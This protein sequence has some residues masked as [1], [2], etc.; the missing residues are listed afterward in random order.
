MVICVVFS[1]RCD[2]DEQDDNPAQKSQAE[3]TKIS[4]TLRSR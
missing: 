1:C 4:D 2:P 3:S